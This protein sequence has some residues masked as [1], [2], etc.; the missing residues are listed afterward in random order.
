MRGFIERRNSK[1]E[2]RTFLDLFQVHQ[3]KPGVLLCTFQA[4]VKTGQKTKKSSGSWPYSTNLTKSLP[5]LGKLLFC[6]VLW[7]SLGKSSGAFLH[8]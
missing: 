1:T 8:L 4:W 5:K 6:S 3:E 7:A 2:L